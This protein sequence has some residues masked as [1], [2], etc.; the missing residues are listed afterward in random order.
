[1]KETKEGHLQFDSEEEMFDYFAKQDSS[2]FSKM[3]SLFFRVRYY[4]E[5]RLSIR[6]PLTKEHKDAGLTWKDSPM[7]KHE[8]WNA[9]R[10][11]AWNAY[12]ILVQYRNSKKNSVPGEDM[13]MEEWEDILDKIIY[14][15][16]CICDVDLKDIDYSKVEVG[17]NL[18]REYFLDLW[19]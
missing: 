9:Y 6:L 5:D 3:K 10:S 1:M 2:M 7:I 19:D 13:S 17:L 16:Y 15:M 11:I 4:L 12:P 8:K 18:F 14:S